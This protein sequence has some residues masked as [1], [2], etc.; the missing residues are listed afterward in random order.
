MAEQK[1]RVD[2]NLQQN[3]LIQA[4]LEVVNSLPSDPVQGRILFKTDEDVIQYFDGLYWKTIS[5]DGHGHG[6]WQINGHFFK[7]NDGNISDYNSYTTL[8]TY[9]INHDPNVAKSNYPPDKVEANGLL[10]VFADASDVNNITKGFQMAVYSDMSAW[11]RNFVGATFDDW[12][13]LLEDENG[14]WYKFRNADVSIVNANENWLTVSVPLADIGY[15]KT[16]LIDSLVQY[17]DDD[18]MVRNPG[19]IGNIEAGSRDNILFH[20]YFSAPFE[21]LGKAYSIY[22]ARFRKAYDY[23]VI[24][25]GQGF[26]NG[27][28]TKTFFDWEGCAANGLPYVVLPWQINVKTAALDGALTRFEI[29]WEA[30]S[31]GYEQST[32]RGQWDL[33]DNYC[34]HHIFF[35]SNQPEYS[36]L[37]HET[38]MF[39][40]T[41]IDSSSISPNFLTVKLYVVPMYAFWLSWE[42]DGYTWMFAPNT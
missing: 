34:K 35:D 1:F 38:I 22:Y 28:N 26:Q 18:S 10:I 36:G 39:Y 27:Q 41:Y 14:T 6:M 20:C 12:F 5:F 3:R 8:G 7:G 13:N 4:A 31:L 42:R 21:S 33:E 30:H 15:L 2:L 40:T 37:D 11:G 17:I 25:K 29:G 32:P 24:G 16:E 9:T 23:A 19:Y